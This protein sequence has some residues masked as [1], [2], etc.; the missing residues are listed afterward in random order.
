MKYFF[1]LI[2]FFNFSFINNLSAYYQVSIKNLNDQL[3]QSFFSNRIGTELTSV[4]IKSEEIDKY[5]TN[6]FY[7]KVNQ[8]YQFEIDINSLTNKLILEKVQFNFNLLNCSLMNNFY[9]IDINNLN[10]NCPNFSSI[11]IKGGN[12]IYINKTNMSIRLKKVTKVDKNILKN[13]WINFITVSP[14]YEREYFLEY[15]RYTDLTNIINYHPKIT[16]YKN[17]NIWLKINHF[18]SNDQINFLIGLL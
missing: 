7:D 17:K 16:L 8:E 12:Y 11:K 3:T 9:S 15:N 13:I 2:L 5:I 18:Y 14:T 1:F 6:F 10:N 4:N